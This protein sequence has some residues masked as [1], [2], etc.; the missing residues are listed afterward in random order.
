MSAQLRQ[1]RRGDIAGLHRIRLAVLENQLVS[2]S[3]SE[4]DYVRE[5]DASGRG[6]VIEQLGNIVAFGVANAVTG[7]I[8]ALFVDPGHERLGYGKRLHDRMVAWLW[9]QGHEKIWL[10]TQA[11]TRAQ[12]FYEAAG[13]T[14]SGYAAGSELRYELS[15][16]SIR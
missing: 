7:S 9:Q 3:L 15:R 6:W 13:W 5:I 16:P 14:N 4:S 12:H 1:A 11:D 10:T 2:T 8:W